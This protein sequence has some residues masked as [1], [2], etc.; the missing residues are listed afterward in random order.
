MTPLLLSEINISFKS[1]CSQIHTSILQHPHSPQL[2]FT[3][4]HKWITMQWW[5]PLIMNKAWMMWTT[6]TKQAHNDK[7]KNDRNAT[8]SAIEV[9]RLPDN[10]AAKECLGL[11]N[12]A[13]RA[14]TVC[15]CSSLSVLY[16]TLKFKLRCFLWGSN[17]IPADVR[18]GETAERDKI[19]KYSGMFS[20]DFK[21]KK[22]L[23]HSTKIPGLLEIGGL[24]QLPTWSS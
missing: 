22:F 7:N 14:C 1:I 19:I 5:W 20:I 8:T 2:L 9:P 21:I 16:Q 4:A 17:Y 23:Q 6:P 24:P 11:P 15:I 10:E 3:Q 12:N 13:G 18:W